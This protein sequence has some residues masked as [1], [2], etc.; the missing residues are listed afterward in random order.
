MPNIT[1]NLQQ[2]NNSIKALA[3]EQKV[4]LIAVSKTFPSTL[5]RQ[6]YADGQ[7]KFA[8]SYPQELA[9][10][11]RELAD[12]EIE[13]HF[14]G[15]IQS[16]KTKLIA[17]QASWVHTITK[18]QHAKRLNDQRPAELAPLQ[19]LIEVNISQEPN[20]YGVN[21]WQELIQLAQ[22][23]MQ[24][25]RLE[26]R[27]LMGMASATNDQQLIQAQF[28][29]LGRY[30]EQ[31]NTQGLGNFDQLSMGMSADYPLAIKAGATL[32]RI[33]SNIFGARTYDN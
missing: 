2:V 20:K 25:P 15:N 8:E 14:I 27:G 13:W 22:A 16:N 26:L 5:V 6:A 11:T 24:L 12:L 18:L 19:I 9:Q 28:Q 17:Q 29:Q 4:E 3:H 7:R 30:L 21:N 33:G 31:L 23:I 32:V 1:Q 10:K